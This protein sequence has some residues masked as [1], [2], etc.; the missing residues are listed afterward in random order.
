MKNSNVEDLVFKLKRYNQFYRKGKPLISDKEFDLLEDELRSI[1]PDNEYFE[2]IGIKPTSGKKVKLPIGMYSLNKVKTIEELKKWCKSK[3]ISDDDLLVITPKFDGA[4]L[5]Q[6]NDRGIVTTRGDGFEGNDV[7]YNFSLTKE[8]EKVGKYCAGEIM[9][10]K[11]VFEEK[12]SKEVGGEYKNSRNMVASLFNPD[13]KNFDKEKL[14]DAV[15]IRYIL[16]DNLIASKTAQLDLLNTVNKIKV[17]YKVVKIKDLTTEYLRELYFTWNKEIDIDGLVIE[18]N[19]SAKRI[20]TPAEKNNNPGYAVAYKGNF[21]SVKETFI[22]S[23]KWQTSKDGFLTPVADI[24]PV[25]LDGVTISNVALYNARFVKDNELGVLARI[26]IKRSGGVI[27]KLVSVKDKALVVDIPKQIDGV[28]TVWDDNEVELCLMKRTDKWNIQ[29]LVHFFRV[30]DIEEFGEPTIVSFY[31]AGLKT[32]RDILEAKITDLVK[33]EGFGKKKAEHLLKEFKEKIFC[34]VHMHSLM[35]ASNCFSG[36]GSKTLKLI[37]D[38]I[39]DVEGHLDPEALEEIDGIG[40]EKAKS[41]V[42]GIDLFD[43]WLINVD[44]IISFIQDEKEEVVI[45]SVCLKDISICFT[46]FRDDELEK[47]II[48]NSGNIV[49]GVNKKT[50]ILLVKEK[51]SGSSKEIKAEEL[52]ISIYTKDEFLKKYNI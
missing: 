24:E 1:D 37:L 34:G 36:L 33:I 44:H 22:R 5:F 4:S 43:R 16:G 38:N 6:D 23:I 13:T 28:R 8:E 45:N 25:N 48:K 42:D 14:Q 12:Y 39:D 41:F 17:K 49:S 35:D 18:I 3:D 2:E 19:D 31:N 9:I 46:G 40:P 32:I 50:N 7:T 27:P 51:G 47:N 15:F 21:E 52:G 11:K 10:P 29:E 26:V 30:L 20:N